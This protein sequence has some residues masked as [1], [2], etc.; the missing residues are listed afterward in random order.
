MTT[1]G[2]GS[3]IWVSL[4][5]LDTSSTPCRLLRSV[6][7]GR[8]KEDDGVYL[9]WFGRGSSHTERTVDHR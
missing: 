4:L 5:G 3:R 8:D 9:Q 6:R 1:C 2:T 7:E